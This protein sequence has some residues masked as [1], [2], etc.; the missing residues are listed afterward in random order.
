MEF[1]KNY[2]EKEAQENRKRPLPREENLPPKKMCLESSM[3]L[4]LPSFIFDPEI[5]EK[6][7][8]EA[9]EKNLGKVRQF[10]HMKG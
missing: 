6:N 5:E 4:K 9:Q 10:E 7:K 2:G 3:D 8:K 1:L